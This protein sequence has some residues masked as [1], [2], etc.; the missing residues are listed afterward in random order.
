MPFIRSV[1]QQ[2]A[3]KIHKVTGVRAEEPNSEKIRECNRFKLLTD[4]WELKV[5]ES[6]VEVRMSLQQ[7]IKS[8]LAEAVLKNSQDLV[9]LK[10]KNKFNSWRN[11]E[12]ESRSK[13]K[14]MAL[15]KK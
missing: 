9:K 11:L 5:L 7:E 15:A 4:Q 6:S 13:M 14:M 10:L 12:L 2:S 8:P 3:N 1:Y